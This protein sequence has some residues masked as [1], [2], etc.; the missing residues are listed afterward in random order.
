VGTRAVEAQT[1]GNPL[2]P[3]APHH[4]ATAKSVI[5]L[6]M[7][8]APSQLDLFDYKESLIQHAG[9]PVPPGL[10]KDQSY[11]FIRP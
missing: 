5:H 11:A 2:T 6:F 4:T 10:I 7:A 9:Q 1:E 3:Q 8:G